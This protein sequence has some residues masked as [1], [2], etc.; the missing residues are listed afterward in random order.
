MKKKVYWVIILILL[1]LFVI[2]GIH[3]TTIRY[4]DKY[5]ASITPDRQARIA[6]IPF[7]LNVLG[8]RFKSVYYS[9]QQRLFISRYVPAKDPLAM[10]KHAKYIGVTF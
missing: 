6:S 3:R 10:V 4:I 7:K 2:I 1:L 8:Y 9:R 5:G